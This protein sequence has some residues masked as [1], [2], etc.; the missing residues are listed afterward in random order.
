M[1][2]PD[3]AQRRRDR[4]LN[5]S[6]LIIHQQLRARLCEMTGESA[7]ERACEHA[8]LVLGLS[9]L[10]TAPIDAAPAR[11]LVP[12]QR[13]TAPAE[14]SP[15]VCA[16]CGKELASRAIRHKSCRPVEY[17]GCGKVFPK[18]S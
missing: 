7:P 6:Q 10:P 3:P 2:S 5:I 14:W 15:R 13:R 4:S 1:N 12:A 11:A 17:L 16:V 8:R 9:E 18:I